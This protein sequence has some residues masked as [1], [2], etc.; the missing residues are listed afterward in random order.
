MIVFFGGVPYYCFYPDYGYSAA[1]PYYAPASTAEYTTDANTQTDPYS[2]QATDAYY[3]PGSQWGGE[4]QQYHVT[5]DQF[6]AYLKSYILTASPV[7]QAAFR[8]GFVAHF[9][10][11][12][13]SVYD[14]A[15]QQAIQP[16]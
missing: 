12:G 1:A 13:Q 5:M 8:S 11:S 14:Q 7:Q 4:M 6:V 15:V 9:G 10:P 2:N 3:Q 16:S